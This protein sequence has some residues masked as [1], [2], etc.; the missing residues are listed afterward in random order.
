VITHDE[1][2]SNLIS[3]KNPIIPGNSHPYSKKKSR[4]N[5]PHVKRTFHIKIQRLWK[6]RPNALLWHQMEGTLKHAG[7]NDASRR[8]PNTGLSGPTKNAR[9]L[10][11]STSGTI[12]SARMHIEQPV[13]LQAYFSTGEFSN[14]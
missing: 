11:S 3:Q 12:G 10:R 1:G 7:K 4:Q 9:G 14:Y 13:R 2:H 6:R 8:P 5:T